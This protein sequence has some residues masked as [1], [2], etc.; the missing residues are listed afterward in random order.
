MNPAVIPSAGVHV[1][2]GAEYFDHLPGAGGGYATPRDDHLITTDCRLT[3]VCSNA[4]NA[5][6][7]G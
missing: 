2:F 6:N 1:D 3:Q 5:C 7:M 4:G